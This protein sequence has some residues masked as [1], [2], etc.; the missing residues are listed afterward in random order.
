MVVLL[1]GWDRHDNFASFQKLSGI[2]KFLGDQKNVVKVINFGSYEEY[3]NAEYPDESHACLPVSDYG[4]WKLKLS[5]HGLEMLPGRFFSL[6]ISNILSEYQPRSSLFGGLINSCECDT[7]FSLDQPNL[8]RTF[9]T[10]DQL[11]ELLGRILTAENLPPI[12]NVGGLGSVSHAELARIICELY[13]KDIQLI[14]YSETLN[15][16]STVCPKNLDIT[17]MLELMS[18]VPID[19]FEVSLEKY[20]TGFRMR[21]IR[22]YG[23]ECTGTQSS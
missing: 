13:Q 10:A 20:I 14:R 18:G 4:R 1:T 21:D 7:H 22:T 5:C 16:S 8:V 15:H 3:G 11:G 23:N 9:I 12:L 6:R 19:N 2:L 17:K